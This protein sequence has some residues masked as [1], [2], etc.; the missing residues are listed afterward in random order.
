LQQI[1]HGTNGHCQQFDQ[2]EIVKFEAEGREWEKA[3]WKRGSELGVL[4]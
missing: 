4:L 3:S 2:V 1:A